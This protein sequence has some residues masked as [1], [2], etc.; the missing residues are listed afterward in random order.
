VARPAGGDKVHRTALYRGLAG[1]YGQSDRREPG[2]TLVLLGV[3][4]RAGGGRLP[5]GRRRCSSTP[6]NRPD[7]TGSAAAQRGGRGLWRLLGRLVRRPLWLIGWSTNLIGFGVRS[8]GP[9]LRSIALVSPY[10]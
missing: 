3:G 8:R 6:R 4:V 5:A 10:S 7:E 9:A 1:R 2:R